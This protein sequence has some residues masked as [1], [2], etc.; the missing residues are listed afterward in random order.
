[1]EMELMVLAGVQE[2]L[3]SWTEVVPG[4]PTLRKWEYTLV[5]LKESVKSLKFQIILEEDFSR[6]RDLGLTKF[7]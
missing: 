6:S 5:Y 4:P 3:W 1:M 7:F 2:S